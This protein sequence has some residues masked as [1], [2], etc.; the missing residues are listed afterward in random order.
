MA[1]LYAI[2]GIR[3][4]DIMFI[5][6]EFHQFWQ[7][8]PLEL[9]CFHTAGVS[10]LS[11]SL[12][13]CLGVKSSLACCLLYS[14][15]LWKYH[16]K[17]SSLP[18]KIFCTSL[19]RWLNLYL[20]WPTGSSILHPEPLTRGPWWW[21]KEWLCVTVMLGPVFMDTD[22][23]GLCFIFTILPCSLRL[24]T[25]IMMLGKKVVCWLQPWF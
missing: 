10:N 24:P 15:R 4:W 11:A 22:A 18:S 3:A 6:G 17:N 9:S 16:F 13:P 1:A 5:T 21:A 19:P 23:T 8:H 2:C 12:L 7:V 14:L 25:L 20:S